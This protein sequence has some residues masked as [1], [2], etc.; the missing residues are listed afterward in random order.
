M[1]TTLPSMEKTISLLKNYNDNIKVMVGGAVLTEEYSKK[2]G[3][4]Y[5]GK[6]AISAV[7]LTQKH[8]I[9]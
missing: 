3:A 7:S 4:D 6:D 1:T 8:Y 9:N 2:I 5:Y